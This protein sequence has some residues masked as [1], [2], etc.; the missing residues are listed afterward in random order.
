VEGDE[1]EQLLGWPPEM[2]I[3]PNQGRR[4]RT[5]SNTQA[6]PRQSIYNAGRGDDT[7]NVAD[8]E[9]GGA[10]GPGGFPRCDDPLGGNGLGP[11]AE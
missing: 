11:G 2:L 6:T 4:M 1:V 8:R 3:A 10:G 5:K 7:S 9:R